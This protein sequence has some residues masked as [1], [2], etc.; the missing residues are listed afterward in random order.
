MYSNRHSSNC[1]RRHEVADVLSGSDL[2]QFVSVIE[3]PTTNAIKAVFN[4]PEYLALK[5]VREQAFS[6][7][8]VCVTA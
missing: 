3:Y 7:Y 1:V 6:R 5:P 4:S 8:E 2:P